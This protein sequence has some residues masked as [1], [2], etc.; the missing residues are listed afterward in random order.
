MIN[1]SAKRLLANPANASDFVAAYQKNK[2]WPMVGQRLSVLSCCPYPS[3]GE[4]RV[5]AAKNQS[6]NQSTLVEA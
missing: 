3:A 6:L 5:E 4:N 1:L 2:D